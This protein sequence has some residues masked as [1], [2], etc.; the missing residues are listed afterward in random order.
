MLDQ[1]QTNPNDVFDLFEHNESGK[2]H[3]KGFINALSE[4]SKYYH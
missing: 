1:L 4:T 3:S 2:I